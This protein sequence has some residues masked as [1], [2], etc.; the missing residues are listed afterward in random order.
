M[1]PIKPLEG[2]KLI[3]GT[4]EGICRVTFQDDDVKAQLPYDRYI[5]L[6]AAARVIN[7]LKEEVS[8][9]LDI[10][11]FDG[12]LA[13]F[14][15][16]THVEIID[17]FTTGGDFMEMDIADGLYDIVTAIDVL[18]HIEPSKREDFLTKLTKVAKTLI[19]INYPSIQSYEAQHVVLAA[20][21]NQFIRE[22]VE[23]KLPESGWVMGYLSAHGFRCEA[24]EYG[25]IALWAGQFISTQLA[26]PKAAELNKYLIENHL[27]EPFTK[28]LYRMVVC[29]REEE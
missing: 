15:P 20:C 8:T 19:L 22:H 13:L 10:G 6:N 7:D 2:L 3:P 26:G 17:P 23:W 21:D 1:S 9:V 27:D 4:Q 11:G 28:P 5:R 16:E 24:A 12:A 18:E 25:N 29:K 14:I